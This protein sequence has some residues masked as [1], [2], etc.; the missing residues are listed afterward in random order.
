MQLHRKKYA[1]ASF[2]VCNCIIDPFSTPFS[3]FQRH[4]HQ[5]AINTPDVLESDFKRWIFRIDG[6]ASHLFRITFHR[7]EFLDYCSVDGVKHE[8][9]SPVNEGA[10]VDSLH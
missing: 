7:H 2:F 10:F 3:L 1:I 8:N 4:A 9:L 5:H 6:N